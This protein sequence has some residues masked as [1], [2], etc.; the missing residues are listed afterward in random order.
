MKL[1]LLVFLNTLL[2]LPVLA[3][4]K[5]DKDLDDLRGPVRTVRTTFI[6]EVKKAGKPVKK[7]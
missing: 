5:T 3:Q 7:M 6:H 2:C 4:Q 1:L